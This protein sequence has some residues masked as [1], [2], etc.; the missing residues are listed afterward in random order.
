MRRIHVVLLVGLVTAALALATTASAVAQSSTEAPKATEIGVTAKEIHIAV[1]ADVDNPFAPG[2][3]QGAVDGVKAGAAYL[4]SKAGGGGVAGRKLVVDFIDT[5]LNANDSRNATITACQNDL[6]MVGGAMLFLSSVADITGCKDQAG[7]ATGLPDIG[8]VI[9]GVPETCAPDVVPV[10][11]R[12]HR[13]RD[14]DAEPADVLGQRGAGQVAAVTAQ[15][16][17]AR[18]DDRGQRHQGRRARRDDPRPA[19]PRPAGIKPDGGSTIPKSGMDP[20]S[21]YTTVVQG[22]K[23]DNSNFSL[24]TSAANSDARAAERGDVAGARQL[25]DRVGMR[26]VLRQ[27]DRDR[28]RVGVRG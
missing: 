17:S 12:R 5:H 28:Q 6:A 4:N 2:L 20:Q 15:G 26:V 25:E 14:G 19:R 21:A 7:Q 23:S 10:D 3:F 13:L 8:S 22:M 11:R 24:M 27:Q 9:T 18:P 1:T 16:W